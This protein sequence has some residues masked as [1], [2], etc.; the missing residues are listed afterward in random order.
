MLNISSRLRIASSRLALHSLKP[1]AVNA[2]SKRAV[3]ALFN[4]SRGYAS[5]ENKQVS[6]TV[7]KFPGYVRNENFKKVRLGRNCV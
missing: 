6:Y 3:P 5:R 4:Y 1:L 2:A 7:D